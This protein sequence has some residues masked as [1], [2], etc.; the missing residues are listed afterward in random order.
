MMRWHPNWYEVWAWNGS[1]W[2]HGDEIRAELV[3][4]SAKLSSQA[5]VSRLM[6]STPLS[7]LL[8]L[9]IVGCGQAPPAPTAKH[10]PSTA[11]AS[12]VRSAVPSQPSGTPSPQSSSTPSPA[13]GIAPRA[14]LLFAVV[15]GDLPYSAQPGKVLIVGLDGYAKAKATF[16]PR[17]LP[18]E[19]F[20]GITLQGVAEVNAHGVFYIDGLGVVRLLQVGSKPK[21]VATIKQ[22]PDQYETWFAVRADGKQ[23]LAGVLTWPAL[24]PAPSDSPCP[25]SFVG[26]SKYDLELAAGGRTRVLQH[27]ES[28]SQAK[29]EFPVGWTA[30]GPIAMVPISLGTQN[31]WWGGPLYMVDSSG[32]LGKQVGGTDCDSASIAPRGFIACTSGQYAV[33]VRDAYGDTLWTTHV[34]GFNALALFLSPDGQAISDG[35]NV[36]SRANG[37]VPM[38]SGFRVEGWLD[39]NT[40]VGKMVSGNGPD[41]GNLSWIGLDDPRTLHDLGFKADFV[42][43][44]G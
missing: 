43:T 7:L 22:P 20:V 30:I 36:E 21:V 13:A 3:G 39:K 32:N 44:I 33:T 34:D 6:R 41:V 25:Y 11:T 42:G 26:N 9:L 18:Q 8:L 17:K 29:V 14:D 40:V 35:T 10:N 37:P 31:A 5:R 19:C 28:P 38:P 1:G 2:L 4:A 12:S 16:Q 24:A 15:E 27:S 23:V